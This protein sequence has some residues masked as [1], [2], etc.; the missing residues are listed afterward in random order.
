MEAEAEAWAQKNALPQIVLD[1]IATL[2]QAQ[3]FPARMA[4]I[5]MTITPRLDPLIT[6]AL[7]VAGA[8]EAQRDDLFRLAATL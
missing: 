5:D 1:T 6:A 7:T 3:Q 8:T 4:A 2:P